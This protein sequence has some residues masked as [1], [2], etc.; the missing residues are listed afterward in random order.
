MHSLNWWDGRNERWN[1]NSSKKTHRKT[2]L[3]KT[4]SSKN[5]L[6]NKLVKNKLIEN[7]LIKKQNRQKQTNSPKNNKANPFLLWLKPINPTHFIITISY[8]IVFY[9]QNLLCTKSF[10]KLC[11]SVSESEDDK[12]SNQQKDIRTKKICWR[13]QNLLRMSK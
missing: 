1:V 11:F 6:K 4:N 10:I 9:H 8:H 12:T 5:S 3:S 13:F 7:E 2:K